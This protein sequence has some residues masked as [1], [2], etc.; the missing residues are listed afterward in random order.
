MPPLLHRLL[1]GFGA[2]AYGQAI[3]IASQLALIPIFLSH[4]SEE[5]YGIWLMISAIPAYLSIADAGITSSAGNTIT[6]LKAKGRHIAAANLFSQSLSIV[7]ILVSLVSTACVVGVLVILFTTSIDGEVLLAT[8]LLIE[9]SLLTILSGTLD[10]AFRSHTQYS[11]G[12][13]LL[14]TARLIELAL[15]ATSIILGYDFIGVAAFMLGGRALFLLI[16]LRICKARFPELKWNLVSP[17]KFRAKL[18]LKP[19]LAFLAFPFGNA[20][21]IQGMTLVI[22]AT[23]GTSFLVIF[24]TYRT[25][26]RASL[27]AI[28]MISRTLWPEISRLHGEGRTD[29]VRKLTHRGTLIL[30][31]VSI[32]V[33]LILYLT[34]SDILRYWTHGKVPFD[35]ATFLLL[36][37]ATALT[38]IWQLRMV[39]LM[40]IN[41]H[42]IIGRY[43]LAT[44]VAAITLVPAMSPL[45]GKPAAG[46]S[47][48]LFEL[49]FGAVCFIE[50]NRHFSRGVR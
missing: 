36:S 16:S 19:G 40:A 13:F 30:S 12:T 34:G 42:I 5:K 18:V 8:L 10:I 2:N 38:G 24:S 9:L 39:A 26:T 27:Q 41:A 4:W 15:C 49:V 11:L 33:A 43:F 31:L 37:I 48:I 46:T 32:S 6:I 21:S 47:L 50:F 29:A 3:T 25:L 45:L 7:I 14:N 44:S 23:F 35:A 17:S 1:T 28:T 22:G 20:I